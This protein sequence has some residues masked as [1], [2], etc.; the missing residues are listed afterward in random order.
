MNLVLFEDDGFRDLLPLT[1]LRPAFELRCGCDRLLD[2]FGAAFGADIVKMLVRAELRA[3]VAERHVLA[4]PDPSTDW[5]F[6]NARALV[7]AALSPP[8]RG[9]AWW[10]GT[11]LIAATIGPA[12]AQTI[13]AEV[14]LDAARLAEWGQRLAAAPPPATIALMEYPWSLVHA[15]AKELFRACVPQPGYQDATNLDTGRYPHVFVVNG[16]AV[17]IAKASDSERVVLK[18]G[19]VLDAE[20]GPIRIERGVRIEPNAVIQG[21][22]H[23]AAGSIVRPGAVIREGTCI[24]P[25]C[26][27]GGEVEGS[28]FQGY[29]N[30][31]HDG[32]LGHSFVAPW[33][34]LGADTVTSDLKNTYSHIQVDLLGRKIESKQMFVGTTFGDHA[35]TG[36]GTILPTGC[37]LGV[38]CNVFSQVGVPSCVPS[39]GWLTNRGLVA[40]E[41]EKMVEIA[42]TVM[43]RRKVALSAAEEALLRSVGAAAKV[44]EAG[45]WSR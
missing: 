27:V 14:F 4:S 15:A 13:D 7:S 8:A 22:C 26:K 36:I 16:S 29:S 17:L 2:K 1:W 42:R 9:T 3:V 31:Q 11:R 24:G 23:I 32:F 38:A 19:V 41:L 35:K 40:A 6:V 21:P 43:A 12:D 20:G 39:F 33:A 28:I 10:H 5:C 34:N 25:V 18:P 45:A 44:E 37:V 30:K